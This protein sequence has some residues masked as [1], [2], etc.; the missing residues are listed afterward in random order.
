MNKLSN[1]VPNLQKMQVNID[2]IE[3]CMMMSINY[4]QTY[5]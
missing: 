2:F 4:T 5:Y 3:G 1:T